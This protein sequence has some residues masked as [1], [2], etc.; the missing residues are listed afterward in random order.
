[1]P[2]EQTPLL[3]NQ[4]EDGRH[5][6]SSPISLEKYR[7]TIRNTQDL[8]LST[9]RE[10]LDLEPLG[11]NTCTA[12]IILLVLLLKQDSASEAGTVRQQLKVLKQHEERSTVLDELLSDALKEH[13]AQEADVPE[14]DDICELLTATFDGPSS[15]LLQPCTR[16]VFAADAL[17]YCTTHDNK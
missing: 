11:R 2:S 17:K 9:L 15:T 4:L 1:M 5:P 16:G 3:Q 6:E 14:D 8:S 13:L 12:L 10:V 7:N